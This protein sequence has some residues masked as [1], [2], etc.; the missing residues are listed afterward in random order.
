[1]QFDVVIGLEIHVQL[2]TQAKLFSPAASAYGA[3]PNAHVHAIDFGLPGTLP[4]LNGR[5]V[6]L[7]VRLGL[8]LGASVRERSCFERKN[9]FY[10]DL[11]K[12][13]QISQYREP[14]IEG[15]AIRWLTAAGETVEA[16]LIRAHL[17]EDAGKSNHTLLP[18]HTALD[19][20]RAGSA[21]LEV[22]TA[23]VLHSAADAADC[24]RALHRLV[25]WLGVCD[26]NL[27]EGSMRADA[28][29]SLK[30]KGASALGTRVEI[31]NL[32]SFRFL[33][34]ALK[35][36]IT[37]QQAL[38]ERGVAIEQET[39][40][41]DP[42]RD[43]TRTMRG[44]EQAM[45]YRYFPDPDLPV[46]VIDPEWLEQQRLA[47]P[48][49][50]LARAQ[51]YAALGL[52]AQDIDALTTQRAVGDYFDRCLA[53]GAP[54]QLAANWMQGEV[55]TSINAL[56]VGIEQAPVTPERLAELLRAVD[57]RTYNHARARQLYAQIANGD[58]RPLAEMASALGFDQRADD[59][60]LD[61][62][63]QALIAAHPGPW[64]QYL[65]G[66]DKVEGFFLGQL[67]RASKGADDPQQAVER[68]RALRAQG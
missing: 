24:F 22:V 41:Y 47:L 2:A 16:A 33:E 14:L 29:V 35:F 10:P 43:Q 34:R 36:E 17:E 8:A 7:A 1:M 32:N 54:A 51:R 15:G 38:L 28:N 44:K 46:I 6:E 48:E 30:P 39:R 56:G 18:G 27:Q 20:N 4:R 53:A 60:G 23:P 3:A 59:S 19:Y 25:V 62:R 12:G 50:P 31:K 68:L 5:A 52:K 21:L 65:G 57:Q 37:R 49:L 55:A 11:A 64:Q 26:G 63:L 45:D 40:L 61:A 9:Y 13:Y 67:M 42:D 66:Q 58:P